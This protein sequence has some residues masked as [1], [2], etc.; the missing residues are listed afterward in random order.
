MSV[1]AY[2]PL[3]DYLVVPDP[4]PPP[5]A[6]NGGATRGAGMGPS[7]A[8]TASAADLQGT[9]PFFGAHNTPLHVALLGLIALGVVILLRKAGFRFAFAGR[10][11]A[12]GR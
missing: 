1:T 11:S 10:V 5:T 8:Q 7:P 4:G 12:G 9:P 6:S 2:N 3:N